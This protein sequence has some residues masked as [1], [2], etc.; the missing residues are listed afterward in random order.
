MILLL[1]TKISVDQKY[2]LF[3]KKKKKKENIKNKQRS[4]TSQYI[5]NSKNSVCRG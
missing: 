4:E 3:I 2:I 5:N 1:T